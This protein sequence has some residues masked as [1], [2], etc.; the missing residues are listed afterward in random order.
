MCSDPG[1]GKDLAI[2]KDKWSS[3]WPG[4]PFSLSF[5][6]RLFPNL[7]LQSSLI[8]SR[9]YTWHVLWGFFAALVGEP[10]G[11]LML[12]AAPQ[13]LEMQPGCSW[14]AVGWICTDS[15]A[16]LGASQSSPVTSLTFCGEVEMFD[17]VKQL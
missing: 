15:I 1:K 17:R 16:Y 10:E 7:P 12:E 3:C 11:I 2:D 13:G 5:S 14:K 6:L 8:C 4:P 9:S